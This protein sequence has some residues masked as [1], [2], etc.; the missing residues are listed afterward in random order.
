LNAKLHR[1]EAIEKIDVNLSRS[2]YLTQIMP[3]E[4][5]ERVYILN[6]RRNF[7]SIA[8]YTVAFDVKIGWREEKYRSAE[9]EVEADNLRSAE[10]ILSKST[11]F[12]VT[13]SPITLSVFA[14]IFSFVGVLM[15]L[16]PKLNEN[17][18]TQQLLSL[19]HLQQFFISG[20][21][22]VIIYNSYEMTEFRDKLRSVSWR[23]AMLIGVLCGLLSER[24]LKA[25]TGFVGA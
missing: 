18:W 4:V 21:L 10:R 11:T 23:S 20:A 15:S 3:G 5:F 6:G 24:M 25:I 1:M 12:N 19:Q 17:L 9:Y 14:M 7:S 2:E 22:A 13:P 8:S 16:L